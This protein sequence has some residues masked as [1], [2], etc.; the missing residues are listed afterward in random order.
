M[1]IKV[2]CFTKIESKCLITNDKKRGLR[3]FC[4]GK[5]DKVCRVRENAEKV[6]FSRDFIS[7]S[8][9]NEEDAYEYSPLQGI[10]FSYMIYNSFFHISTAFEHQMDINMHMTHIC[11]ELDELMVKG[12]VN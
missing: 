4:P 10:S 1:R 8:N 5:G 11:F 2:V 12:R 7:I 3:L 9:I 6:L